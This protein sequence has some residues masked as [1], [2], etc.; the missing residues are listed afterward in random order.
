MNSPFCSLA[1]SS[2]QCN[3]EKEYYPVRLKSDFE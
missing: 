1:L 3:K 2:L